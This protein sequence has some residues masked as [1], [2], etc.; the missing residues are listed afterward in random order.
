[1]IFQEPPKYDF[2]TG[3]IYYH[4]GDVSSYISEGQSFLKEPHPNHE[5]WDNFSM[6]DGALQIYFSHHVLLAIFHHFN[7]TKSVKFMMNNNNLFAQSPYKLDIQ[8][9][10]IAAPS[11]Y[12]NYSR[13]EVVIIQGVV[14]E[15]DF[16][17]TADIFNGT[18]Y[19]SLSFHLNRTLEKVFGYDCFYK[20]ENLLFPY[21]DQ[22]LNVMLGELSLSDITL[23][24][25]YGVIDEGTLRSWTEWTFNKYMQQTPYIL[26]QNSIDFSGVFSNSTISVVPD[27][28][29]LIAGQP[30]AAFKEG[31][32]K[33]FKEII[34][35]MVKNN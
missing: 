1:M 34:A 30:H 11:L 25:H 6:H 33:N 15:L 4:T 27:N 9:L 35:K 29:I 22:K 10:G 17:Q 18:F 2:E 28:G 19:L 20:Y 26:F 32:P 14:T 13:D 8:H 23:H 7:E 3:I 16:D 12:S 21:T 31:V 5:K 24:G